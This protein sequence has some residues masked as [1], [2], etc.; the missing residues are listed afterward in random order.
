M[1]PDDIKSFR[2]TLGLSRAELA[3]RLPIPYR[4]LED[5][6]AGKRTAP[7]YLR[8]ALN[9]IARELAADHKGKISEGFRK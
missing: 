5:W 6:E 4:T 3:R 8:R 2:A 9:D 1:T 7:K